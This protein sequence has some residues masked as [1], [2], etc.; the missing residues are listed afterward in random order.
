M[1][2]NTLYNFID[3]QRDKW[4]YDVFSKFSKS[5]DMLACVFSNE[6]RI[7]SID[8]E[9]WAHAWADQLLIADG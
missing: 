9:K 6:A 3:E 2:N 7:H 1:N 8:N 5:Q 4:M